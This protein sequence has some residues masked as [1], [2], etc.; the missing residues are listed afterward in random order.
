MMRG[1]VT[2]EYLTKPASPVLEEMTFPAYRRLLSLEPGVRHPELD[3]RRVARPH[4]MV[5]AQGDEP[6]GLALFEQAVETP[7]EAEMLSLFVTPRYRRR[8]VGTALLAHVEERAR[9][10]GVHRLT[11]VYMTGKPAIPVLERLFEK[12]GWQPPATRALSLRF[13]PDEASRTPWFG[14]IRLPAEYEI[15]PWSEL[16]EAESVEIARSHGQTAWIAPGLE[17][18]RHDCQGFDRKSSLGLRYRGL[19]VGWV[20]NHEVW[21]GA[22]RFTCS[23]VRSDLGRLGRIL[24]L[25]TASILRLQADGCRECTLVAPVGYG[26]M[27]RFLVRRCSRWVRETVETRGTSKLLV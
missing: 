24:A 9:S 20:I 11:A 2:Y 22:V 26:P 1:A 8:G 14:Q 19:V 3:Q 16:T 25:Y 13:T 21:P 5:A 6:V 17:P 7:H 15:F 18:W 10:L 27:V 12:S 23:F 4:A